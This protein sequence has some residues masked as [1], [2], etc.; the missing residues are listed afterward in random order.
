MY[1]DVPRVQS[2]VAQSSAA[3]DP[4]FETHNGCSVAMAGTVL[5]APFRTIMQPDTDYSVG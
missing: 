5:N 3:K 4:L 2:S 1:S